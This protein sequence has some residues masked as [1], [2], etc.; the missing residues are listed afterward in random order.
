VKLTGHNGYLVLDRDPL[1][2]VFS[3]RILSAGQDALAIWTASTRLSPVYGVSRGNYTSPAEF[4]FSGNWFLVLLGPVHPENVA[5]LASNACDIWLTIGLFNVVAA[6]NREAK[7]REIVAWAEQTNVPFECWQVENGRVL[8]TSVWTVPSQEGT[9]RRSL[10]EIWSSALPDE[11][12][13]AVQEY[14]PLMASAISRSAGLPF[15]FETELVNLDRTIRALLVA[16]REQPASARPYSALGQ[17]LVINAG[18][19]RFS[20]QTFAGTTPITLTE[21]HFWLHS[22]LGVGL[23]TI[24]LRNVRTFVEAT[25]GEA[26]LN[27]RF[28]ALK[29]RKNTT[30]LTREFPPHGDYLGDVPLPPRDELIPLLAFFSARDG[31]RSTEI[32]VS[33]PLAA[34]SACNSQRWSLLTLTHEFCHVVVRAIQAELYPNFDDPAEL[35]KCL[36]LIEAKS[37]ANNTLDEIRRIL[38]FSIVK[39]DDAAAD[40]GAGESVKLDED[41]LM[42]LLQHWR[43]DVDEIFVHVFDFM[44]FYGQDVEKY[45]GAIWASWGTIPNISTRVLDYLVRTI[46]AVLTKH[47]RRGFEGEAIAKDQVHRALEELQARN[48][49]D[50]YVEQAV[51]CLATQWDAVIRPRVRARRQLVKIVNAYLFS[52]GIATQV[53]GEP[54]ISGGASK[55]EGYELVKNDLELRRVGNPLRFLEIYTDTLTPDATESAWILYVLAFCVNYD[56]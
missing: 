40:R 29:E 7:S 18:L 50:R 2:G 36:D 26:R 56:G 53:R 27:K 31:Y 19:S 24:A 41:S 30:D 45:I 54:E 13:E 39:M 46:C 23:A 6:T 44:H 5:S 21:C 34:V 10:V 43:Q 22:L 32:S 17:L 48:G 37:P 20:S 4:D 9:W 1:S 25:L 33:A 8:D 42:I 51:D 35:N 49:G 28:A 47:I 12:R 55:K 52:E 14:C 38:L 3:V 11:L 16:F 15:G